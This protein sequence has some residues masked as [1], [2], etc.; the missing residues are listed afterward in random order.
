LT[1]IPDAVHVAGSRDGRPQDSTLSTVLPMI[2]VLEDLVLYGR[3]VAWQARLRPGLP[4]RRGSDIPPACPRRAPPS[5]HRA[6]DEHAPL[7]NGMVQLQADFNLNNISGSEMRPD[8]GRKSMSGID[9]RRLL[10]FSGAGAITASTGGVA[11]I[12]A[13]GRAPVYAQATS[14]HWLR[15]SDFVPASDQL[16]KSRS[17]RNAKKRSGSS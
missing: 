6:T 16:L 17:S 14:I 12:L 5:P 4:L 3:H 15:W 9:R 13:S 11:A 8:V 10:K 2:G 7:G 1:F